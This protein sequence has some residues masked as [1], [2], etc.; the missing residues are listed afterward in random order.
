MNN[1]TT[2]PHIHSAS[3]FISNRLTNA[4]HP[5]AMRLDEASREDSGASELGCE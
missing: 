4:N 1:V 2:S 5:N 3:T